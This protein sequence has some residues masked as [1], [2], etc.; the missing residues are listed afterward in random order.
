M[1]FFLFLA[2]AAK[3]DEEFE[4]AANLN[5]STSIRVYLSHPHVVF[6]KFS[7]LRK[8]WKREASKISCIVNFFLFSSFIIFQLTIKVIHCVENCTNVS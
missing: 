8:E 2:F 3:R 5:V 7:T 4:D 1:M 6:F